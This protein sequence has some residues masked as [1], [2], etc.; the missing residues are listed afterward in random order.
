MC[1]WLPRGLV[2]RL[3][4][5]AGLNRGF[6]VYASVTGACA[7]TGLAAAAPPVIS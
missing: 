6:G 4:T 7:S 2:L 1:C 5:L 3:L